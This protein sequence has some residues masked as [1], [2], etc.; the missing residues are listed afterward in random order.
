MNNYRKSSHATYRCE[1]HFVWT[2]EYRYKVL[3]DDIKPKLQE[4]LSNLCDWMEIE[5]LEGAIMSDHVHLYLSV[6]PKHS[7]SQVMKVLKGKS[8]EILMK[9]Y[10]KLLKR[11]Y[12]NRH[13]WARGYFVTTVGIN[14]DII[15]RYVKNQFEEEENE[16][17]MRLWRDI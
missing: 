1:Y 2:P 17:Q 11:G 7:L 9:R 8:A 14:S 12:G 13:L 5:L 6:P 10:P 4:I 16:R 3:M 15:K